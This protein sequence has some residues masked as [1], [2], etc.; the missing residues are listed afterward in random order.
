ME[1]VIRL[2]DIA[3]ECGVTKG[4]VSRALA[5]K[6][7]VADET[8]SLIMKKAVE[9]GYDFDKLRTKS[10]KKK[11]VVIVVSNS[12]LMK[13]DYWQ[14]II[15][16][17]YATLNR[18][19]IRMEYYVFDNDHIDL[20]DVK[21]LKNNPCIAFVVLHRNPNKIFFELSK[22]NKPIIEVDPKYLHY[23]G[24]TQIKYSNY[25]SMYEATERLIQYGHKHICFYGSDMHALSFRERH[26]G[27]LAS[28]D[29][30][31]NDGIY[32]Y[33]VIFDNSSLQYG[34]N[35][36]LEEALRKNDKITAI[37]AAN[38]ICALNAYQ[39]IDKLGRKIPDDYSIIGFDNISGGREV[40]PALSTFNV[41]REQIGDE[42]GLYIVRLLQEN[43]PQYSEFIIRC[44]Y[45]E[46]DSVKKLG[47]VI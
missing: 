27:F 29:K 45:I 25:T 43:K 23:T 1:K 32:G 5:G 24:V 36:M 37:V 39:V 33:E 38:D 44:D 9:L 47:D 16:N 19:S 12:I 2:E 22:F 4:L 34:D 17:M 42:I 10:K 35:E 8:R 18:A 20:D 40:K 41:P 13:E 31:K 21:K 7:N 46:R 26:E 28:I 30:N 14:P 11:S 15:K 6:Y 3:R